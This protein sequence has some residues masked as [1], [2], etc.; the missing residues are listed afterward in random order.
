MR[1]LLLLSTLLTSACWKQY[2]NAD[3]PSLEDIDDVMWA[4]DQ[5]MSPLFKKSDNKAYTDE[6][7]ASFTAGSE[8]LK[9]TTA[10][11]KEKF[12]R[13]PEF[14]TFADTLATH[15]GE[16][17]EAAAAKDVAKASEALVATKA[18]CKACHAKKFK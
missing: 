17:G 3:I 7:W 12:S 2:T 15:G 8:R 9:L 11:L 1:N 18:T 14:N 6:E 13:G 10:R 16:L 4:Q 5:V